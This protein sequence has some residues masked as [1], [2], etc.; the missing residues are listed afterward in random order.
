MAAAKMVPVD[1][2]AGNADLEFYY[3]MYGAAMGK[4]YVQINDGSGWTTWIL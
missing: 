2:G 4:L 3:H 1:L